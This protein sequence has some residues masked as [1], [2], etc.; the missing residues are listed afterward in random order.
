M[1]TLPHNTPEDDA[2]LARA[3][4]LAA[5]GQLK[6]AVAVLQQAVT[7][8][9]DQLQPRLVLG[10]VLL[11][12]GKVSQAEEVLTIVVERWPTNATARLL[13]GYTLLERGERQGAVEQFQ[14]VL[15]LTDGLE[16][17]LSAHLGLASVYES[18]G[19]QHQADDHYAQALSIAPELRTVLVNIQ[20]ALLWR[21]PTVTT[22]ADIGHVVPD[23]T[24]RSRIEA[25]LEKLRAE[26]EKK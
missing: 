15:E 4:Q 26:K 11:E 16:Q 3:K 8:A 5:A 23:Q 20:K 19:D 12:W 7:R 1:P 21:P 9:P 17:S 18:L 2:S 24:R 6:D 25:E 14:K 22:G 10:G 13:L